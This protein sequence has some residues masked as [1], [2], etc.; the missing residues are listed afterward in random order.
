MIEWQ[1]RLTAELA[2][3]LHGT[4]WNGNITIFMAPTVATCVTLLVRLDSPKII[5]LGYLML[6]WIHK[7]SRNRISYV[8]SD[9]TLYSINYSICNI[10]I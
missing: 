2:F 5:L 6:D 10:T 4:E 8:A 1:T 7:N 3:R 9:H